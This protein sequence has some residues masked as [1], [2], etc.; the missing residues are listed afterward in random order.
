[1]GT[2]PERGNSNLTCN[3]RAWAFRWAH[4]EEEGSE[5]SEGAPYKLKDSA[6]VSSQKEQNHAP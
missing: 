5:K 3:T 1:M 2:K 4:L 6:E